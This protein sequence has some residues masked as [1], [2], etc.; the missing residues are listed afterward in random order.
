MR[1]VKPVALCALT[2]SVPSI[3]NAQG[4]R[5]SIVGLVQ[6]GSGGVL[7][8]VT[9]EASSPSLIERTRSVV[10]D[11]AGRYAI[12]NLRPGTYAV[13]F[14]LAGFTTVKREGIV[15]EGTFAAPVNASLSVGS[16]QETVVVTGASP[17][18]DLQNTRTQVVVNQSVLQA[19]PVMRSIQD[20][21]NLI[22]GVVSR[23]TSAGQIL[24]DFYINSMSARGSTDQRIYFDGMGGGNMMLGGGTQAI[25]GGVNELGQAEMVYDVGSQSAESAVSG[26]RMDAI[27][28]DGGNTFAGT[29]RFFGSN[30]S[31]QSSNLTDELRAAGIKAVNKLDFNWDSNIAFGGPIK[32]DKFWFFSAFELSQFNILVANVFFADGRQADTGGH[33]KPNGTAR[34]TYQASQKDKLTLAYFNTTSLTDRY[35]FSATTTP[36]AGL[37]VNS[38]VNYSGQLKWTR[39]ATSR[40]LVEV[41]QSM[42]AS[43]YHWEYQPE[44]GIYEVAKR[45][46]TTGVTSNASSIAPVENFNQSYST[47]GNVSY[48]TGSH[49]LK[50][51]MN[52]GRGNGRTRVEP[53]GDIVV[54]NF[55]TPTSGTVTIR[56]SPV[57]ARERLKADLGFYLQD[58]WTLRRLTVTP[59]VR[60]DY[61]NAGLPAQTAPAGRFVPARSAPATRCLPCWKDWSLRLGG[62]YDLFGNGKTALK[63][64]LGKYLASMALG[65]AEGSN[66][67]RS[68]SDSRTW[69]DLDRNGTALDANGNAQYNEIAAVGTNVNF[70]LPIGATRFD[71]TTPRPTNWEETVSV[72]HEMW[73]GVAVTAGFYHRSF[74]NQSISR[75]LAIS[76]VN[77]YTPY[78][79]VAPKDSRLPNGGGEAITRYNLL[80]S[81]QLTPP[82]NVSTYSTT[83]TR[84][85]NGFE[86]SVNARMPKGGFV[87]GGITT[88][89]TA[90]SDCDVVNRD[91]NNLRFCE[92]TPPF[93]TLYKANAAYTLPYDIQ[94]SGSLQAVPGGDVSATFTYNSAYAG[95]PLTGAN[96][97]SVNLIEPNTQFFDYQTQ[98]DM[99]ASRTFRFGRK[100][101]QGYVDLFNVL[102]ASTVVSFNQTFGTNTT[103]NANYLQPLVVMQA[104]RVQLGGRFDF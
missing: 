41:G 96:S 80:A 5:A 62:S 54:L 85:Y 102:N 56:N 66:P 55:L 20:Q 99:R 34:L 35:D 22:P 32:R 15:L 70:G 12:E 86:V 17:V 45:N 71:Q 10:T 48:V 29:Y 92:S 8:G 82:D 63:A 61:L 46:S 7:P 9:V 94:V 72:Q 73:S 19:L 101:V 33:V 51:G 53:H 3:A 93:R 95:I 87:L 79:I 69:N 6:D 23:S 44:V 42:A 31:L 16:V 64:S 38:P 47:L 59:G 103:L 24:S 76:N 4:D 11:G 37:R 28:K 14:T 18:V 84:V 52:L 50:M 90:T 89:R 68:D 13:T 81:K 58:K 30:H 40:L 77:D 97:R 1:F 39:T 25:A 65:R 100:R 75:N 36:E 26:V 78:A 91:P 2:L 98:L 21:A 49:A 104:R 88:Q 60:F 74:Q 57:T 67:I 27:P 43:T 83:N